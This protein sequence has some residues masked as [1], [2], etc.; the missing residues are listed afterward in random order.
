VRI[1]LRIN[2]RHMPI[3]EIRRWTGQVVFVKAPD[4]EAVRDYGQRVLK[5]FL[6][7]FKSE[8]PKEID[9]EDGV[10][11]VIDWQGRVIRSRK[12]FAG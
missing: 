6:E 12:G 2:S 7:P 10:D 11:V 4:V 3:W 5:S 8:L 9:V 1:E